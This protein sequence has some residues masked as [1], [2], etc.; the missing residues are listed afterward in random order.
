MKIRLDEASSLEDLRDFLRRAGCVA[1]P[2]GPDTLEV[3][4]PRAP[5]R[6]QERREVEIYLA[7]WRARFPEAG[8]EFVD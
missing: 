8:A 1:E 7:V 4:V 5:S 6:E 3:T 2:V